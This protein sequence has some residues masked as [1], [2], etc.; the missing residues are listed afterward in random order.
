MSN[1][2]S[3]LETLQFGY[4]DCIHSRFH[5][6][7][8]KCDKIFDYKNI[9]K[10]KLSRNLKKIWSESSR[11]LWK[12]IT[13]KWGGWNWMAMSKQYQDC[14]H[15]VVS[16]L[17]TVLAWGC[18]EKASCTSFVNTTTKVNGIS[19]RPPVKPINANSSSS[20]STL[21]LHLCILSL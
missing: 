2:F 21:L 7:R 14:S 13:W 17:I 19:L 4:D 12:L 20:S 15:I 6:K 8:T 11:N 18:A 5:R 16:F 1:Y 9:N 3:D 10:A